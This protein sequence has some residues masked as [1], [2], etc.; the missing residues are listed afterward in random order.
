M[1][2][3]PLSTSYED[4]LDSTVTQ[5]FTGAFYSTGSI[6]GDT[7]QPNVLYYDETYPGTDNQRWRAPNSASNTIPEAQGLYT[8]FFGDI[9]SDP[10]YNNQFPLP[11]T[12]TVQGQEH[13]GDGNSV[14]FDV[15]YTASADSGWNLVGNP[16][17]ATIDWDDG[18]S[19]TKTNIDNTIYV[20]DS[21]VN[22][23]K[24]WNGTTGDLDS[25]GLIAPFQGFWIK[26][27][28]M[29]PILE[30]TED[31]KTFDGAYTGK[32]NSKKEDVPAI[33]LTI[34]NDTLQAS[35]HFM[36]STQASIGKDISDANRLV[37]P[38]G[39]G[40]FVDINSVTE[41]GTRLAINNL[42]RHFGRAIEIPIYVNAYSQG[43]SSNDLL[44]LSISKLKNIPHGWDIELRDNYIKNKLNLEDSFSYSFTYQGNSDHTA[45][46]FA[47]AGRPKIT[48]KNSDSE[49]R[50]TLIIHP[51]ED[52]ADLPASYNLEQNYP[53]PFNPSTNIQFDLP[54]Q[55]YTEI[56][57]FSILGQRLE[58]IVQEE[59]SAGTHKFTWDASGYASGI[60][61]YRMIS[62]EIVITKQMTLIK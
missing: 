17:A 31:A 56:T 15:T 59:L 33:S 8:F 16:Y 44:T 25:E 34:S 62:D 26:A 41:N 53:N 60:Y 27:N 1:I 55:S 42:P 14:D 2:S 6:P 51:G 48:S 40:H 10:L 39:I 30:V 36:F 50:F 49:P 3:S 12:L 21:G 58:T 35:T 24:T 57:V 5:G 19:W 4:L 43:I 32:V 9:D 47:Y 29:N 45:P 52:G 7:L 38:P 28:D 54:V 18:T 20:W 23:F 11:T 37:P 46:N 22:S 61:L 13:D